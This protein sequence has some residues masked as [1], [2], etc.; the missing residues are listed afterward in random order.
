MISAVYDRRSIRKFL[1]KP[2]A[3]EDLTEI[4]ES[5][6]KA[7]SSKNRQPWKFVVVQGTEKEEMLKAFAGAFREKKRKA[8]CCREA[9]GIFPLQ[10]IRW[11]LWKRRRL[12]YLF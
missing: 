1:D 10:N 6:I 4:L 12:S 2:I 9:D 3:G 11:I 7:P 5:G 8:H